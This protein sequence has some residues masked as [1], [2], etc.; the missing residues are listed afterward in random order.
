MMSPLDPNRMTAAERLA[1]LARILAAGLMRSSR[2][3]V[4]FFICARRR[5]FCRLLAPEERSLLVANHATELEA[6]DANCDETIAAG[7]AAAGR[8]CKTET[9]PS[10][11][12]WR[13]CKRM[14]VNE[15]KAKWEDPARHDAPNNARAF[16]SCDRLSHPGTDLWRASRAKPA[17]LL[18]A[19]G[20]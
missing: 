13:L 12:S 7:P 4:Q 2:D 9:A 19:S 3:T 6:D 11:R 17:E 10:W 18:D 8:G 14:S 16:W 15:L 1:E 5:Q 20:R